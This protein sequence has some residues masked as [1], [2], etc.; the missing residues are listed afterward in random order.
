MKEKKYH[1]K[2]KNQVFGFEIADFT[3]DF[4]SQFYKTETY[5]EHGLERYYRT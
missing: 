1:F 5:F 4:R 3:Q 2:L